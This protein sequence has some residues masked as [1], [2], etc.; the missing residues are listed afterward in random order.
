VPSTT[1]LPRGQ[2]TLVSGRR[3]NIQD[4]SYKAK[5]ISSGVKAEFTDSN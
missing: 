3:R 4:D 1:N 2:L 5:R